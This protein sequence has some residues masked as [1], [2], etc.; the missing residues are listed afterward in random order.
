MAKNSTFDWEN[1]I[2]ISGG[3]ELGKILE[4]DCAFSPCMS[5]SPQR[6]P[7]PATRFLVGQ[8][9]ASYGGMISSHASPSGDASRCLRWYRIKAICDQ[10]HTNSRRSRFGWLELLARSLIRLAVPR[11]L[12]L[13]MLI[14]CTTFCSRLLTTPS[15]LESDLR[16]ARPNYICLTCIRWG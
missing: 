9:C 11:D 16:P 8:G 15:I 3:L 1:M 6:T 5:T 13:R 14:P 7:R 2:E 4:L 12:L 10:A